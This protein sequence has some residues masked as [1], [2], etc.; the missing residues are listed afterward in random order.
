VVALI[1][2]IAWATMRPARVASIP[3]ITRVA[4]LIPV[5]AGCRLR[6][7]ALNV[8]RRTMEAAQLLAQ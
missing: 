2:M 1:P 7:L 5:P 3:L 4:A 8:L 6:A